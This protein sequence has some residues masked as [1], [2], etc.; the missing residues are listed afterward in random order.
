MLMVLPACE[1]YKPQDEPAK[2][3]MLTREITA[4]LL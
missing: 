2:Q 3:D 4:L 1:L